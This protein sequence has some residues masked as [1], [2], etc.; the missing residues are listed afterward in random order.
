MDH[1]PLDNK[2]IEKFRSI[3]LTEKQRIIAE[4]RTEKLEAIQIDQEDLSDEYDLASTE[5]TQSVLFRLQDRERQLLAKLNLALDRL[6][7][8]RFGDCESCEEPIEI[9]R[10]EARPVTTHCLSCKEQE[11]RRERIY[12]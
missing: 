10:L 4:G 7:E 2:T 9:K 6:N 3:L 1:K 5:L 8:G 12:A 11:E